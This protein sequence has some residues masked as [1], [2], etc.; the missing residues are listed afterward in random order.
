MDV[1]YEEDT[2]KEDGIVL[3]QS[4]DAGKSVAEGTTVVITVNKVS[5]NKTANI[6]INLKKITGG[7]DKEDETIEDSKKKAKVVVSIESGSGSGFSRSDVDKNGTTSGQITGV[8]QVTVKVEITDNAGGSWSESH[9]MNLNSDT[10][11]TFG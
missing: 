11:Y 2:T 8:G 5:Q 4:I 9:V 3:K 1:A 6:T 10:S 7:Y